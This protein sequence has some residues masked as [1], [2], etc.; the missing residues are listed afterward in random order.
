LL[1]CERVAKRP[2]FLPFGAHHHHRKN[3]L[4]RGTTRRT[5][6]RPA[7]SWYSTKRDQEV[8]FRWHTRAVPLPV[9]A[10][11]VVKGSVRRA[12]MQPVSGAT[13]KTLCPPD[14]STDGEITTTTDLD[15]EFDAHGD[16]TINDD[17]VLEVLVPDE[18]K[19]EFNAHDFCVDEDEENCR[20]LEAN[21]LI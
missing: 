2:H 19:R 11:A 16:G 10:R 17:C 20:T 1:S 21:V 4:A 15:G 8:R 18:P 7:L 6:T 14:D 12:T 9:R 13:V 3:L 5:I